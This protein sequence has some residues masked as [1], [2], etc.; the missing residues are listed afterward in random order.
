MN[1]GLTDQELL[2]IYEILKDM[3]DDEIDNGLF[4]LEILAA[5]KQNKIVLCESNHVH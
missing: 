5:E 3:T 2:S 1:T 4:Q